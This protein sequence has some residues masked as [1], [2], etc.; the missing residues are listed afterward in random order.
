MPF[1]QRTRG[2][3]EAGLQTYA[4]A[5]RLMPELRETELEYLSVR[6]W[7]MNTLARMEQYR[8]ALEQ[9]KA[10]GDHA[11]ATELGNKMQ[12]LQGQLADGRA[13]VQRAA[14]GS[15]AEAF[16]LAAKRML[17]KETLMLIDRE[18]DHLLG[19]PVHELTGP[20]K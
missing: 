20:N 18:A 12:G 13:R 2:S 1:V 11:F 14:E 4:R 17:P 5:V 3:K 16:T 15:W 10:N 6:D 7:Y 9:A 19:R 8:E